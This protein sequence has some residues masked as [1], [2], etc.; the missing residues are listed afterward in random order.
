MTYEDPL[1]FSVDGDVEYAVI[2]SKSEMLVMRCFDSN[3]EIFKSMQNSSY[4]VSPVK[5]GIELGQGESILTC[6]EIEIEGSSYVFC[7]M[8]NEG[9][10]I[11]VTIR[12]EFSNAD[13]QVKL[14]NVSQQKFSNDFGQKNI[15]NGAWGNWLKG[16]FFTSPQVEGKAGQVSR[17]KIFGSNQTFSLKNL[18]N[19]EDLAREDLMYLYLADSKVGKFSFDFSANPKIK[20]PGQGPASFVTEKDLLTLIETCSQKIIPNFTSDTKANVYVIDIAALSMS[21]TSCEFFV[22]SFCQ[23]ETID[24]F[25]FQENI[26]NELSQDSNSYSYILLMKVKWDFSGP[27]KLIASTL[28]KTITHPIDT[29]DGKIEAISNNLY[30]VCNLMSEDSASQQQSTNFFS[31]VDYDLDDPIVKNI[32][33]TI[34]G[35]GSMLDVTSNQEQILLYLSSG[36]NIIQAGS[37]DD[38]KNNNTTMNR[39]MANMGMSMLNSSFNANLSLN[40]P[41]SNLLVR[42]FLHELLQDFIVE[43][44]HRICGP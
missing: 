44:W 15:G 35:L 22:L 4:S 2:F 1:F 31:R 5:F 11:V 24:S 21:Q 8:T 26:T 9:S 27:L 16:I 38:L 10:F 32:P 25:E 37:S 17:G 30:I 34:L 41:T 23:I 13:L 43:F 39:S 18:V 14:T 28:L 33:D 36:T 7:L 40:G 12:P 3:R 42:F 20:N 29:I 19:T 6:S